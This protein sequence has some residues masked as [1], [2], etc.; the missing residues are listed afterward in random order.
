[1]PLFERGQEVLTANYRTADS[2]QEELLVYTLL[3][4]I[5]TY[6][7]IYVVPTGKRF[8]VSSIVI[9]NTVAATISLATG[10]AASEADFM[11]INTN[12]G[13]MPYQFDF[14]VPIAFSS[15]TRISGKN[16]Q[17]SDARV[18]LVGFTE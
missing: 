5:D 4:D 12:S 13:D 6:E 8:Y 18:S 11:V 2:N 10:A 15:D 14:K 1:M 17:A 7:E 3:D 9:S 16:S